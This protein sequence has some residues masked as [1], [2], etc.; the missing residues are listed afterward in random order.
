MARR[1][2]GRMVER[3]PQF[4]HND[5]RVLTQ[6]ASLLS[7]SDVCFV[8]KQDPIEELANQ[9]SRQNCCAASR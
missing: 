1:G 2:N 6:E 7:R 9:D 5:G 8:G 3:G 4:V